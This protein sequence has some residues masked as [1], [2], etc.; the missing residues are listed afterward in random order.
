MSGIAGCC[1]F[2]GTAASAAVVASLDRGI[3]QCGPDGRTQLP[4]GSTVL[5]QRTFHTGRYPESAQHFESDGISIVVDGRIENRT[6]ARSD[7]EFLFDLYRRDPDGAFVAPVIGDFSFALWDASRR[8]L[9][10]SRDAFGIRPLFYHASP[11]RVVWSTKLDPLVEP[12]LGIDPTIDD[13]Y[14]GGYMTGGAGAE[15]TPYR[16]IRVVPPGAMLVFTPAGKSVRTFWSVHSIQDI[17]LRNDRDYEERLL[18]LLREAVSVRLQSDRPVAAELSGGLDSSTIVCLAAGLVRDGAVPAPDLLTISYVFDEATASDERRYV[19]EVEQAVGRRGIHL[20]EEDHR[21]LSTLAEVESPLY[22]TPEVCFL[23]RHRH[24][25]QTM[26]AAGARVLMR[27]IGGD[28]VLWGEADQLYEPMDHFQARRFIAMHRSLRKWAPALRTSYF[29]LLRRSVLRPLLGRSGG[30]AG[31]DHRMPGWLS[32][33]F[34]ER[35]H[36]HQRIEHVPASARR[37]PPSWRAQ[38]RMVDDLLSYFSLGYYV[39]RGALDVTYPFM[40]RPLVEL[41]LG[42]PLE[43]KLRPRETRS[44]LRR[45]LRD[46]LPPAIAQRKNKQG[47][48][49]AIVRALARE[50]PVLHE[51]F[52]DSRAASHGIIERDTFLTALT[53]ARHG[54]NI[55]LPALLRIISIECWLRTL[56]H[57]RL[58]SAA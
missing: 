18:E 36:V 28:Q 35:A 45:A 31:H 26:E 55:N 49:E 48:D 33:D 37:R 5:L 13:E 58:R 16:A 22:P 6:G 14:I 12:L 51:M 23:A 11:R 21:I 29:E 38:A 3:A 57:R 50:W 42:M 7:A 54:V 46:V 1:H 47:P 8:T 24:V 19:E 40:H 15:E 39:D 32:P 9:I 41:C 56:E 34:V 53:R 27:G 2:D 20:R 4:H 17:T 43:Q 10:L 30:H 25:Q 52:S 44:V